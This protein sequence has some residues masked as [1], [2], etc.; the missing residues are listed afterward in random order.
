MPQKPLTEYTTDIPKVAELLE[1][2]DSLHTFLLNLLR[3]I[4][5]NGLVL[6]L[7][8]NLKRLKSVTL[9]R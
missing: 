1:D 5:A 6:F 2:T 7:E 4:S 8:L 9:N 3:D